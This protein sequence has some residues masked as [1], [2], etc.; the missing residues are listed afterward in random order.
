MR[1]EYLLGL[2]L[3]KKAPCKGLVD[4]LSVLVGALNAG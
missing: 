4:R 3:N 1:S 2:A